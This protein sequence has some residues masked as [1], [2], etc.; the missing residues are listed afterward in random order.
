MGIMIESIGV[1]TTEINKDKFISLQRK[2]Y[3]DL[4]PG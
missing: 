4:D 2:L 3:K 1:I